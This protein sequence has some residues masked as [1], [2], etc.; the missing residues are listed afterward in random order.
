MISAQVAINTDG[1]NPDA[2]AGLDVKFNNKG[3]L[4]PRLSVAEIAA[5]STPADG[6][7]VYNTTSWSPVPTGNVQGIC[8]AG[9][10]FTFR[11]RMENSEK[12]LGMTQTEADDVGWRG[13]DEGGKLKEV[14]T[15]LGALES[16]NKYSQI[17]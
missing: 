5:I 3:F 9:L 7:Q 14:G 13:T 4:L 17:E 8:P 1:S 2:S 10:A 6:L 15:R 12:Y 16:G 11:E